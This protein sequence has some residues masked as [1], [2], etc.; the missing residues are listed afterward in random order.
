MNSIQLN[1]NVQKPA[2][3]NKTIPKVSTLC[4]FCVYIIEGGSLKLS[5]KIKSSILK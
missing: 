3:E 4:V 5:S 1:D 2:E